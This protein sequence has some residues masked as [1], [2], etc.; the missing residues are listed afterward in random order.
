MWLIL[1]PLVSAYVDSIF[2]ENIYWP[3]ASSFYPNIFRSIFILF[4][5]GQSQTVT[6]H[7]QLT[8]VLGFSLSTHKC[9]L[10]FGTI[11]KLILLFR[12][13]AVFCSVS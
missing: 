12:D 3:M 7:R 6:Q 9:C 4:E 13:G 8:P 5:L 2:F 11:F 10:L 1:G